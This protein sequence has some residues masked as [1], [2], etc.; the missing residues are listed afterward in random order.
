VVGVFEVVV[1]L[2][3]FVWGSGVV[4]CCFFLLSNAL[5]LGVAVVYG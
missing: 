3:G 2:C 1:G 4:A 5:G